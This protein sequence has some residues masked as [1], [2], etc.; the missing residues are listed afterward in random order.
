M[1]ELAL[2]LVFWYSCQL[3]CRCPMSSNYSVEV[4]S[5]E[6]QVKKRPH[7]MQKYCCQWW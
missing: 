5:I 3:C 2:Q 1:A 6:V 7:V 4:K